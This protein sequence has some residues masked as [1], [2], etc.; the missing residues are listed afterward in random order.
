VANPFAN[1]EWAMTLLLLGIGFVCTGGEWVWPGVRVGYQQKT[2]EGV[3]LTT[4]SLRPL[5]FSVRDLLTEEECAFIRQEA[6]PHV[7][8]SVTMKMV[9]YALIFVVDP[10]FP[11]LSVS[12]RTEIDPSPTPTGGPPASTSSPARVDLC[13]KLWTKRSPS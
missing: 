9:W 11:T 6:E 1:I 3:E 12:L 2:L 10:L 5:V 8:S 13:S 4:L 7:V